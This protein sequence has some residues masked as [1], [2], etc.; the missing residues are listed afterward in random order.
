[1]TCCDR[2]LVPAGLWQ[3]NSANVEMRFLEVLSAE[4]VYT[5][6]NSRRSVSFNFR[7]NVKSP[8]DQATT[9][10]GSDESSV[11]ASDVTGFPVTAA[12]AMAQPSSMKLCSFMT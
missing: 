4:D 11:R 7:W 10:Y 1:M 5:P 3:A 12:R 8:G 9:E 2:C 6:I